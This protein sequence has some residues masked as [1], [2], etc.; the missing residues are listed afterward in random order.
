[1]KLSFAQRG[2]TFVEL[3]VS[4]VVIGIAVTALLLAYSTTVSKSADPMIYAQTLSVAA[5]IIS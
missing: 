3:V 2:V 1:M 5:Q 4:I